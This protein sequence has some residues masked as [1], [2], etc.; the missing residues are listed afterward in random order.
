VAF[1]GRVL[2]N[3]LKHAFTEGRAGKI[4]ADYRSKG[5]N[6]TLSVGDNGIGM[7]ADPAEAKPGLGTS[8]VDALARQLGAQVKV[9]RMKPGTTVSVIHTPIVAV[10]N[11]PAQRSL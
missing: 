5:P 11:L 2:I 6:W 4:L 10:Q 1:T 9:Q 8:I 3:A 7:P